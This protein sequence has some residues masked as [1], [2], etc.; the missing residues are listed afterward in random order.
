MFMV[1]GGP[2]LD[3]SYETQA[4]PPSV[5]YIIVQDSNAARSQ[6]ILCQGLVTVLLP[7]TSAL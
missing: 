3:H 6:L 4:C 2:L 1:C 5:F 7:G